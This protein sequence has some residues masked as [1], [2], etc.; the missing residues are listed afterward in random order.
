MSR[1]RA[2]KMQPIAPPITPRKQNLLL[3]GRTVRGA[4]LAVAILLSVALVGCDQQRV[5]GD[6]P[7]FS[8]LRDRYNERTQQ[9]EQMWARSTV[10]LRWR[11]ERD[12]RQFEQGDGH[13]VFRKPSDFALSLG[14][15][16]RTMYWVGGDAERFWFFDLN[17][18]SGEPRTATLGHHDD[19]ARSGAEGIP[20]PV[21]PDQLVHL[22]GVAEM[23]EPAA[24]HVPRISREDGMDVVILAA[25]A[26]GQAWWRYELDAATHQPQRIV[27][28]D[29]AEEVVVRSELSRYHSLRRDGE[30]PGA[31]PL[32]P[33]RI[34]ITAPQAEDT[35]LT[36]FLD[37]DPPPTDGKARDRVREAQFDFDA[38]VNMLNP[39]EVRLVEADALGR[40]AEDE[41]QP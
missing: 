29:A 23:P 37:R 39:D 12:R 3:A 26:D 35:R 1:H 30:P 32:I 15:A 6:V 21:R 31:W 2:G 9:I 19:V 17:P 20:V 38:L 16:G 36:L 8:E 40:P 14:K 34:E 10:E 4:V 41:P 11:D 24:G 13:L 33:T 7:A 18:P 25:D 27:L 22:L 28:L 5:E